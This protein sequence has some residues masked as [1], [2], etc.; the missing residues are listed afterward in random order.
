[1]LKINAKILKLILPL[2]ILFLLFITN[3]FSNLKN[4]YINNFDERFNKIY[5]FCGNESIGYLKYLKKKVELNNNPKI[6]NYVHTP[7]VSWAIFDP[8]KVNL[9]SNNII[10]LN[11]PGKN[12]EM[13][14][15]KESKDTFNIINLGNHEARINKINKIIISINKNDINENISLDLY[16]QLKFGKRDF[17]KKFDK[18]YKISDNQLQFDINLKITEIFPE[19]NNISFKVKNLNNAQIEKIQIL[20]ENKFDIS[21]FELVD[22]YKKC[23]LIKKK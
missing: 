17:I 23:F 18:S 2:I 6:V 12:F 9:E 13:H 3:F 21:N 19:N 10:L 5:D 4:I 15:S 22:N 20:A 1:M 16:S 8:N 7:S 14:Y 11:Y